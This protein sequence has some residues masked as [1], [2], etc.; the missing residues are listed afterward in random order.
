MESEKPKLVLDFSEPEP[1]IFLQARL[2]AQSS[3][4][5]QAKGEV[6]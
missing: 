1:K 5:Q 2:M 3:S 4:T 6:Y